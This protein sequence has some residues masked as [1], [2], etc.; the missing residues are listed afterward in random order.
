MLFGGLRL[1]SGVYWTTKV[2]PGAPFTQVN[3]SATTTIADTPLPTGTKKVIL[4]TGYGANH[5]YVEMT[6]AQYGALGYGAVAQFATGPFYMMIKR[7][8]VNLLWNQSDGS[9][10]NNTGITA[11]ASKLFAGTDG[12]NTWLVI[13]FWG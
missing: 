6:S 8:S 5:Q 1:I 2:S 9:S 10:G 12:S 7:N 3:S 4:F 13:E 11:D